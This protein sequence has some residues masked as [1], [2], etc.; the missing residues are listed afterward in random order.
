[1]YE[2][3]EDVGESFPR[4]QDAYVHFKGRDCCGPEVVYGDMNR[5]RMGRGRLTFYASL[6]SESKNVPW[7]NVSLPEGERNH[8]KAC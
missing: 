3:R 2:I 8:T 5:V 4:S 6:Q 7:E 1:M